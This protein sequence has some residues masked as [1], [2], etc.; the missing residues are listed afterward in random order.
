M[1]GMLIDPFEG[2]PYRFGKNRRA[3]LRL[4][5]DCSSFVDSFRMDSS[6][7]SFSERRKYGCSNEPV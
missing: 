5:T 4:R 2:P 7:F 3:N 1:K 6:I